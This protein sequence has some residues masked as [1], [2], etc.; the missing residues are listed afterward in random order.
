MILRL[1]LMPDNQNHIVIHSLNHSV[2]KM[3][4]PGTGHNTGDTTVS[5][6]EM[7]LAL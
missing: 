1:L 2:N 7:A 6:I 4:V 5:Q 3:Y